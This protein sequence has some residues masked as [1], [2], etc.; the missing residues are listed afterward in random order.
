MIIGGELGMTTAFSSELDTWS[1]PTVKSWADGKR[2]MLGVI[3]CSIDGWW[4]RDLSR[5]LKVRLC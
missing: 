5:F 2:W 1:V 4:V 3:N